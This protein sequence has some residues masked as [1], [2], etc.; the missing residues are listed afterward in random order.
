MTDTL[1][2]RV[3]RAR[4]R[5]CCLEEVLDGLG[6]DAVAALGEARAR[7]ALAEITAAIDRL[8]EPLAERIYPR[9]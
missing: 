1:R 4:L 7:A 5:L 3:R 9:R 2:D 8:L 6:E